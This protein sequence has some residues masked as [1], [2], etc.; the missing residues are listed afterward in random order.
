MLVVGCELAGICIVKA[1]NMT[2][3]LYCCHMHTETQ[4]EIRLLVL[5]CK[6]YRFY[7]ALYSSVAE[8]AGYKYTVA[9]AQKLCRSLGCYFFR[10]NELYLNMGFVFKA[11]VTERFHYRKICVGQSNIF[12]YKA[13]NGVL[14][15]VVLTLYHL[16]PLGEVGFSLLKS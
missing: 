6:A 4:S 12:S 5:S 7:L 8:A 15:C 10:I 1:C 9:V 14:S 11:C 13:D 2:G 3:K 16:F